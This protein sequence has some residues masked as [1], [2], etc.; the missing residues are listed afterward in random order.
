SVGAFA[1]RELVGQRPALGHE[2]ERHRVDAV[3][4]AGR[5]RPVGKHVTLM[6][7]AARAHDLGALHAVARVAHVL[8]VRFVEGR[9]KARP[10]GARLE[11]LARAKQRQPAQAAAVD[12]RFLVL[13]QRAAKR[14]FGPVL[15]QHVALLARERGLELA[16]L[17]GTRRRQ[18]EAA[19][20][21]PG[22]GGLYFHGH[23]PLRR[24]CGLSSSGNASTSR[25]TLGWDTAQ[26]YGWS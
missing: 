10:A 2:L 25:A 22:R 18:I 13:E 6:A 24:R 7:P 16:A 14:R 5:R 8:Q 21:T 20:R 17:L 12:A 15:E 1:P 3:A 23:T 11:L 19:R 9:G 4:Q 26:M